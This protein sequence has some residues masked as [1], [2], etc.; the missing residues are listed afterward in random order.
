MY[1]LVYCHFEVLYFIKG[2]SMDD[3]NRQIADLDFNELDVFSCATQYQL[4]KASNIT[5]IECDVAPQ[6]V[7]SK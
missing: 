7:I 6:L 1:M 3:I 4:F 2:A 5:E